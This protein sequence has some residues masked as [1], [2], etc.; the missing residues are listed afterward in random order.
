[1]DCAR[2]AAY[3]TKNVCGGSCKPQSFS[4]EKKSKT[5]VVTLRRLTEN[6]GGDAG[7]ASAA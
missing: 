3:R 7:A 5:I 2:A 6:S 1:V 4:V